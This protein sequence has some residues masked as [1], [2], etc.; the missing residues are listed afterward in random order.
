MDADK[1]LK[2]ARRR[3]QN[4]NYLLS[5]KKYQAARKELSVALSLYEKTEA[6]RETA[7]ALNNIGIT[8]VKDGMADKARDFFERSYELKKEH[9]DRPESRF[10]TL[11][12]LVGIPKSLADDEFEKYFL[13]LKEVGLKLGGEHAGIV[14]R[15][16]AIYDRL[17]EAR[18][19]E[20]QRLEAE[21]L[22]KSSPAGALEHLSSSG[23]PCVVN[24]KFAL[25]GFSLDSPSFSFEDNGR[26]VTLTGISSSSG[27]VS[28]ELLST[29]EIEFEAPYERVKELMSHPGAE[30]EIE[31]HLLEESFEYV[32]KFMEA[33]AMVREDIDFC[34]EK[35]N[36]STI[37]VSMINA[38]GDPLE[39]HHAEAR[40]QALPLKLTEED[41]MLV[42]M[43][44]S[45]QHALYK[46]MLL[47]AK[48]LLQEENYS[49]C[50]VDSVSSF[51][52]FLDLLLK[53]ALPEPDRSAYLAIANPSLQDRIKFMKML[54][55]GVEG[56]NGTLEPYLG[57]IG[58][59]M[60]D[61][62]KYYGDIMNNGD[63]PV[64]SYEAAKAL[65]TVNR[66]IYNL[67]SLY[68][69]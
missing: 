29:G 17:T 5:Q 46:K 36:Y 39:V 20:R 37:S 28:G 43:M 9:D 23:R 41:A 59:D 52:S 1:S 12:N 61:A 18:E 10:N 56:Q 26:K 62:L 19:K 16:Q 6:Y 25:H 11:Y 58:M 42:N 69:I 50:I 51:K 44:L 14:A 34:L 13:E 2:I 49:L 54:I 63:K 30:T 67:K 40:A 32:K 68:D 22:A 21:E 45:T 33:V 48:R 3:F 8:F 60:D 64:R 31:P 24:V 53:K 38:F 35:R 66:A 4:G 7:E 47:N 55:S 65:K 15:E 57:E 27:D